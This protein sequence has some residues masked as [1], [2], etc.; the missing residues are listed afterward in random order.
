[1][2]SSNKIRIGFIALG[3]FIASTGL[4]LQLIYYHYTTYLSL[5]FFV[6][7]GVAI[8]GYR[9]RKGDKLFFKK[10]EPKVKISSS[11]GIVI[12]TGLIIFFTGLAF[13]Y[14]GMFENSLLAYEIFLI[15]LIIS[16]ILLFSTRFMKIEKTANLKQ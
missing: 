9:Y 11:R 14:V 4:F 3:L 8:A 12:L 1:M 16:L 10:R 7:T 6:G 5:I 2:D 15:F 13:G